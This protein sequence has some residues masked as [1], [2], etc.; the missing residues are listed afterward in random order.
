M[1]SLTMTGD[2]GRLKLEG[3]FFPSHIAIEPWF[4]PLPLPLD[5]SF[6]ELVLEVSAIVTEGCLRESR[7]PDWF[8]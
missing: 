3:C 1:R 8:F 5:E 6:I 4:M 2:P 7:L